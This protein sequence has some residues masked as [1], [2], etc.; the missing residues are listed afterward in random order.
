MINLINETLKIEHISYITFYFCWI[1][2]TPEWEVGYS[3]MYKLNT[4]GKRTKQITEEINTILLW[5]CCEET[6]KNQ[7]E[8]SDD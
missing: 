4:V 3:K 2:I 1:K 7:D 5:K 6:L 8:K